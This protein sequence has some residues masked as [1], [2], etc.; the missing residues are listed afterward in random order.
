VDAPFE[1]RCYARL[2]ER[3]KG[4]P[5]RFKRGKSAMKIGLRKDQRYLVL[6]MLFVLA[7]PVP[8]KAQ[9]ANVSGEQRSRDST[10]RVGSVLQGG[11]DKAKWGMT[12]REV[13][14]LYP[15]GLAQQSDNGGAVYKIR[16]SAAGVSEGI[17][18]FYFKPKIGLRSVVILFAAQGNQVDLKADNFVPPT[19]EQAMRIVST[20]RQD[21]VMKHGKPALEKEG[22]ANWIGSTGDWIMLHETREPDGL[23]TTVGLAY[24]PAVNVEGAKGQ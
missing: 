22:R 20:L 19:N 15:G 8:A 5:P 10:R 11:Y 21:L 16:K 1:E 6:S 12:V 2:D 13:K 24:A 9:N 14:E 3:T 18:T 17:I 7:M 4:P 23:H